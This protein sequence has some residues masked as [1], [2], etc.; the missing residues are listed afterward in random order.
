MAFSAIVSK[1]G[2][3]SV[4]E[5]EMTRRISPVAV[6]CSRVSVEIAVARLQLLEQADVLDGDD[7][8]VGEGLEELDLRVGEGPGRV[9][10]TKI[11]PMTCPSRTIGTPRQAAVAARPRRALLLVAG[12]VEHVRD[13]NDRAR[14]DDARRYRL[15]V[16]AHGENVPND[17]GPGR[18]HAV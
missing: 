6:C 12:I 7:G 9:R 4:G 16:R 17:V 10:A 3:T 8:L 2:W 14:P 18:R 13:V 5:L 11:T 1:T 15:V